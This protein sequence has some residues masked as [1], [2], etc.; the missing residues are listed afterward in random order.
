MTSI[1]LGLD[2]TAGY[3]FRVDLVGTFSAGDFQVM[4]Y[5]GFTNAADLILI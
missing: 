4:S 3:D 5:S 2:G 1:F